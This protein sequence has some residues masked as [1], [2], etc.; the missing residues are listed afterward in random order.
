M[1]ARKTAAAAVPPKATAGNATDAGAPSER[2]AHA[3]AS[4]R[5]L[6]RFR[7]VFN[8]VKTHFQQVEKTAGVGGA[9]VWALSLVRGEPGIGI[10]AL[11]RAM[12]V[13]QTTA[14]NLVRAL[15]EQGLA[16]SHRSGIDR[17]TAQLKVTRA[18]M[19]L[20]ERAPGP[21]AGVLPEALQRLD[22]ATLK[23]L[24]ADLA[25]LL[26]LLQTDK[27]AE[28]IPLAEM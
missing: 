15:V 14:S 21:F 11:A 19:R 13:H 22:E 27:R 26:K 3:E 18:G 7:S 20:L 9:Q 24:D 2:A 6:R 23:R 25:A 1:P 10:G 5:V 4:V 16:E 8:A 12:D 17:R 28:H